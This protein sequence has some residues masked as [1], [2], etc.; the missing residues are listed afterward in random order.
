MSSTLTTKGQI[1]IPKH[2]RDALGLNPGSQVDFVLHDNGDI[3]LRK[4]GRSPI[5]PLIASRQRVA[6]Q[7][8]RGA[9][10]T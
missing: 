9:R 2:I 7:M 3:V 6:G 8:C 10:Q 1:T 4:T 5:P